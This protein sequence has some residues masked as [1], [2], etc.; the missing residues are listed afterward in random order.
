MPLYSLDVSP[1]LLA[2]WTGPHNGAPGFDVVR[3]DDF[4]P[5]LMAGMAGQR[6]EIAALVENP[7]APSFDNTIAA[8]ERSGRSLA[9]AGAIYGVWASTLND[10][11]MQAVEQA[12]SP[13]FAAF[14]DEVI[15]NAA[16]F[17]RIK[18]V[19]QASEDAGL[20]SEQRRLAEVV[21]RRFARRGAAL[22][23]VEK[24]RLAEI[25]Q[26]L[27]TLTTTFSQN[28]L[29]DEESA[30]LTLESRDDL[31]GLPDFADRGRGGG[32]G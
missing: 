15:Q 29:A 10:K 5:A 16:L 19:F 8:L 3:I 20:T 12:M 27:A 6:A 28:V 4:E 14:D 32:S 22:P 23:E 26:R 1:S 18:R 21:Y 30:W 24:A 25:N 17:S 2:A 31:D 7:D 11:A 9:R 13:V